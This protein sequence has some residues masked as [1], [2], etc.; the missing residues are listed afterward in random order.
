MND[1]NEEKNNQDSEKKFCSDCGFKYKK[2]EMLERKDGKW[3][4]LRCAP[5][6]QL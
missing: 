5:R 4:C 1:K 2:N 3:F 6:N